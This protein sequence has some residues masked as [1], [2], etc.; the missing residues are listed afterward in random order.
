MTTPGGDVLDVGSPRRAPRWLRP[1]SVAIAA[2]LVV[3]AAAAAVHAWQSRPP[4]SAALGVTALEIIGSQP[5][6]IAAEPPI[7]ALAT[8]AGASLPGV[9]VRATVGGDPERAVAVSAAATD[10]LAY[11]QATPEVAIAPGSFDTIDV[12]LAPVDC[13]STQ[14]TTAL[15]EAGYRWRRPFGIDLLRT[16]EGDAVPM[17]DEAREAFRAALDTACTG[18]GEAPTITVREARL[19]GKKPLETIGLVVDVATDAERLVLTPLDGPGLRGL[20]SADRRD[21]DDIPLLWLVSA[22]T[23]ETEP[24]RTA[25]VQAFEVRGGTA[26]PWIIAIPVPDELPDMG[27]A[28]RN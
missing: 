25:Y 18:A 27:T 1:L 10:S 17:S 26:Y 4:M 9:V 3:G 13:A 15:D 8:P 12:T 21:G 22:F 14:G 6:T 7:G 11:I 20:G 5:V 2:L 16:S 28:L 23:E 24:G 19:G